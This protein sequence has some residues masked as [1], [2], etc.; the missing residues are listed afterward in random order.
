MPG[1]KQRGQLVLQRLLPRQ[2]SGAELPWHRPSYG[3]LR[4]RQVSISQKYLVQALK[5]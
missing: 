2:P 1:K 3:D 5:V 4:A